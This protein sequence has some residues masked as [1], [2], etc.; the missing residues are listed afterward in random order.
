MG[1]LNIVSFSVFFA[2][3]WSVLLTDTNPTIIFRTYMANHPHVIKHV[4]VPSLIRECASSNLSTRSGAI[5]ACSKLAP[6]ADAAVRS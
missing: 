2:L 6:M 5:L 3:F 4:I 1:L